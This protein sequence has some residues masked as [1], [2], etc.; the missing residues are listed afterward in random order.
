MCGYVW[1]CVGMRVCFLILLLASC[2]DKMSKLQGAYNH[3]IEDY[4]LP[5]SDDPGL[6]R[7]FKYD[8]CD[9]W[10]CIFCVC[11]A[12]PLICAFTGVVHVA[13]HENLQREG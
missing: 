9:V 12:C 3:S 7:Q 2:R 1:V 6:D 13:G 8:V 10:C 11:R 5:A 4:V